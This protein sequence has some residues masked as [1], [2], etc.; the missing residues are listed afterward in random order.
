MAKRAKTLREIQDKA[1]LCT[2]RSDFNKQYPAEYAA[3][4]RRSDFEQICAHMKPSQGRTLTFEEIRLEANKYPTRKKFQRGSPAHYRASVK[5]EDHNEICSH[6]PT[7]KNDK[8]EEG[9]IERIIGRY[10][11]LND[12]VKKEPAAYL[13]VKR[14]SC[15]RHLLGK[16]I[17]IKRNFYTD[18]EIQMEANKYIKRGDFAKAKSGAYSAAKKRGGE[19]FDKVCSHMEK[20]TNEA[21]TLEEIIE[22]ISKCFNKGELSQK[23]PGVYNAA[24][25]RNDYDLLCA[26][27]SP[28]KRMSTGEKEI[29]DT[30]SAIYPK[31]KKVMDM[32]VKIPNKPYIQGF[33]IDIFVPELNKGI[34]FDGTRWHSFEFMRKTPH[35]AL[36]SDEDIHNYH[37]LKDQ[38]FAS[39][40]IQ[41]LH[42]REED[43]IEDKEKC[44]KLC[45]EFLNKS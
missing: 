33:E 23:Y 44:I 24:R 39:K 13:Y 15:F 1:N 21:Y 2:R 17:K 42:I 30:V 25:K 41:I 38:W 16:L 8:Y 5:R 18:A 7:A 19:F 27:L 6:M 43:W 26:N 28:S 12:F 20:P 36:W 10:S 4:I 3:A 40:G 31:T 35:K 34:E 9:E 11:I 22:T 29:F 32:K 14:S 37:Q 45:L